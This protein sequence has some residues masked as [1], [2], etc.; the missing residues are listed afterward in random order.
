MV[1]KNKLENE[2][3]NHVYCNASY[4]S[5]VKWPYMFHILGIPVHFLRVITIRYADTN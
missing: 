1:I 3:I 4:Q 5:T 2:S